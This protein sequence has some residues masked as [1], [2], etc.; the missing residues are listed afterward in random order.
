MAI[1]VMGVRNINKD[2]LDTLHNIWNVGR[3]IAN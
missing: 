1:E 2:T 3:E